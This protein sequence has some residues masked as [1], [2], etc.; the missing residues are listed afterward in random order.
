MQVTVS[1][2]EAVHG[3]LPRPIT[4]ESI[5]GLNNQTRKTDLLNVLVE[6]FA[7]P[8]CNID[9]VS[10]GRANKQLLK[11]QH[12]WDGKRTVLKVT[13]GTTIHRPLTDDG[14]LVRGLFNAALQDQTL[15]N[16][17]LYFHR[18]GGTRVWRTYN[19][20]ELV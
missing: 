15:Q 19:A 3:Y 9:F 5:N 11:F 10:G 8:S 4:H 16:V 12:T 20:S 17:T 2:R 13:G 1:H 7:R 14:Q 6:S 18:V